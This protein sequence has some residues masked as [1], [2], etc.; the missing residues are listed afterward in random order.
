MGDVG[1]WVSVRDIEDGWRTWGKSGE[2][3]EDM[4]S[5]WALHGERRRGKL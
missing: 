2:E 4:E 1:A 3:V 5:E